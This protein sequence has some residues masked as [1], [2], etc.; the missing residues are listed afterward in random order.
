M[1]KLTKLA[2]GTIT[3]IIAGATSVK[4]S[5]DI[6]EAKAGKYDEELPPGF[7]W[8]DG[9]DLEGSDEEPYF[10]K[11]ETVILVNPHNGGYWAGNNDMAA[12]V[13]FE[14]KDAKYDEEDLEWRYKLEPRDVSEE[15]CG[16]QFDLSTEWV[17]EKW[18]D[19]ADKPGM[20]RKDFVRKAEKIAQFSEV[21]ISH[22]IDYWLDTL[23]YSTDEKERKQAVRRLREL[24]G[25]KPEGESE[26]EKG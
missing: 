13:I 22:E 9:M 5:R 21:I 24:V 19:I 6:A 20:F 18:L 16:L 25:D 1:R 2:L 15:E 10:E 11:G 17:A 7:V 12:P 23:R 3:G 8:I 4:L 14:V 26:N